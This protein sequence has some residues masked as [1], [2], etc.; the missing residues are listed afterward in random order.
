MGDDDEMVVATITVR[1]VLTDEGVVVRME[2]DPDDVALV[3]QLGMLRLCEDSAIR[4]EMG[5]VDEEDDE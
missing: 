2:V 1:K 3:D 4:V 5:E